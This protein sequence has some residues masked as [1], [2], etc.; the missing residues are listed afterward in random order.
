MSIEV[1]HAPVA[2]LTRDDG[3]GLWYST[4]F[5]QSDDDKPLYASPQKF[6]T[7]LT[8][9]QIHKVNEDFEQD[10]GSIA[11]TR[12]IEAKLKELNQ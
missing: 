4:N 2:W 3:D 8:D 10:H 7:D 6:W 9:A 5:K 1:K 11:H 12:A